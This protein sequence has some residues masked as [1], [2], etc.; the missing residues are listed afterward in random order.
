MKK[1]ILL[2]LLLFLCSFTKAEEIK[3]PNFALTSH[4]MYI[5][6]INITSDQIL[7][8]ITIENKIKGGNFC[9]DKSTYIQNVLTNTKH[10]LLDSDNIPICPEAYNFSYI[11]EKL[12][13]QLK[14][15][16]PAENTKYLNIIEGCYDHCFSIFGIILDPEMNESINSAFDLFDKREYESSQ[17]TLVKIIQENPDYPFGFLY[18]NLIQVLVIQDKI[19]E[20]KKYYQYLIKSD[21]S[22]KKFILDQLKN[23][24]HLL[25]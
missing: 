16:K 6:N 17:E 4:P 1:N 24:E 22:D 12:T 18:L 9:V 2:G 11:D 7:I 14:F 20:A 10:M 19:D 25:K 13:F 15:P 8:K 5:E 21:Y 3:N 23:A